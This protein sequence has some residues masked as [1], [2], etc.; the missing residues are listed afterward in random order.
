MLARRPVL[1]IRLFLKLVAKL[2]SGARENEPLSTRLLCAADRSLAFNA[3]SNSCS[4]ILYL[5]AIEGRML[6]MGYHEDAR[7]CSYKTEQRWTSEG[8]RQVCVCSD[9]QVTS[10]TSEVSGQAEAETDK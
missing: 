10:L 6:S 7:H 8:T 2:L 1:V 4:M 3:G 9:G 5:L